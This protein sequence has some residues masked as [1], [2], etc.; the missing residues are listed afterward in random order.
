MRSSE[1]DMAEEVK[2]EI[3]EPT[4]TEQTPDETPVAAEPEASP[5]EEARPAEAADAASVEASVDAPADTAAEIPVE[6]PATVEPVP[7]LEQLKPESIKPKVPRIPLPSSLQEIVG[8]LLFASESPLTAAELRTCVRGVAPEEGDDAEVM[9]VY[10]GCTSREIDQAL[11]GLEK[12]LERSGCGF[13]LVCSGGTYRL[14]T[15][16]TCGRYVRALLKLDRP[17]RLSRASLETLAI[18]AY[19]QPITKAEIEQI[20]GVAVDTIV[21]SLVELQLV[22]LVGRSELPGHPFLY[23]TSPL[24]L[25]H[26]GL[27]SLSELN[28]ID[29]TLQRSNPRERAKLFV[30]EKKP[31]EKPA[32]AEEKPDEKSADQQEPQAQPVES[33]AAQGVEAAGSSDEEGPSS[34]RRVSFRPDEED[35]L[36][37]D[38]P[39]AFDDEDDDD[40]DESLLDD[41]DESLL[42]DEEEDEDDLD[43]DDDDD[44][45]ETAEGDD[46]E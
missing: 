17:S 28:A 25:E 18:I 9:S 33:D 21:K 32:A 10:Q 23:G 12:E 19:R 8:A 36:I 6:E 7:Q 15:A 20:R 24:F 46:D 16:P 5:V 26:F 22:R 13:R 4:P 27:A 45:G 11:R 2:D 34:T 1:D 3:V 39:D 42:D 30:K 38:T 41:D 43:D 29:P 14:Q 31:E 44:G 40:D 37:D 35:E